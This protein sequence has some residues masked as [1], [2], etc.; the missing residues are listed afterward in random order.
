M[1]P[2]A[3]LLLLAACSPSSDSPPASD[4]W[5]ETVVDLPSATKA[6]VDAV[7]ALPECGAIQVGGLIHWRATMFLCGG[8]PA[9]GCSYPSAKP[10]LIEVAYSGS[11][12]DG[13]DGVSTLAH[14]LCH[15]CGY[16]DE[17]DASACAL[18]ALDISRR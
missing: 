10:P 4:S 18:R 3:L 14:E 2:I 1:R 15:V 9:L 5:R 6:V 8:V 7:A 11:A 16:T 13:K 12:W 17:T